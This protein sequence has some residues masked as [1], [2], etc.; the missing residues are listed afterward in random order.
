MNNMGIPLFMK[1]SGNT[2]RIAKTT[3]KNLNI[4]PPTAKHI[5]FS[6]PTS[7]LWQLNVKRVCEINLIVPNS[8]AII[9]HLTHQALLVVIDHDA[10][11]AVA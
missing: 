8:T 5:G 3:K 2:P 11:L 9:T 10:T 4:L 1:F 6:A 7:F